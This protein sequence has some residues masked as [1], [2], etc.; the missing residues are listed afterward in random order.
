MVVNLAPYAAGGGSAEIKTI[1]GGFII[2][3]FLGLKTLVVKAVCLPLM[4]A[5]GLAVGKEGPMVHVA[6]C[7]GNCVGRGFGW[8]RGSE[9]RKR[10]VMSAAAGAGIAVAFGA[11]I[12][13]VLF[14][15]EELSTFFPI[16]TMV[17]SFF[18]ALVSGVTL[19]IIDPYRGKRV[20]YQVSYS[21]DWHLFEIV[22]F[23]ILGIFGGITGALAIRFNILVQQFRRR[24]AW[25]KDHPVRE[26]AG[27]S[28]V[29][30]GVCYLNVYTR[31]DASELLENLF[32]EC[33]E[34]DFHGVCGGVVDDGVTFCRV[35]AASRGWVVASLLV[36][37]VLRWALTVVTFGVKVPAGIL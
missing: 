15:L 35:T 21:R 12:G 18:C 14:S 28:L 6:V 29:T 22:F 27:L 1:L 24:T 5:S 37:V 31:A 4:V 34:S 8:F 2:K 9:A 16:K 17:R 10:E 33:R 23:L 32:K 19:S 3:G 25:L 13:G 7:V 36:A 30:A 20:L 26:V 11:P